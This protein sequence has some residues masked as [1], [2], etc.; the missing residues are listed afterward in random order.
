VPNRSE[1][2]DLVRN[3][4][5]ECRRLGVDVAYGRE[6]TVSTVLAEGPDAVVLATGASPARPWWAPSDQARIVDVLDVLTGQARPSGDVVVIDEL[7]FH[8]ATS[9]AELL[10]DRGC[11]VEILTPGMVVGQDL[12][13]T[14]DLENWWFRAE[15]KGIVQTT[16]AVIVGCDDNGLTVLHHPTGQTRARPFDWC[17]LAV[18]PVPVDELYHELKGR[19]G[20]LHRVGDCLAPRRAHAAVVEGRRVGA[21]L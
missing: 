21:A 1:L 2:G 18:P 11:R 13:V 15:A 12:G 10:A 6:A 8:Q 14:L 5:G 16:D 20:E 3:L 17:V 7:G 9:V 4:L 19:V